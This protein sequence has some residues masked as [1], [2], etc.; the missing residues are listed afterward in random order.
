MKRL[1]TVLAVFLVLGFGSIAT[2]QQ[3]VDEQVDVRLVLVEALV[4]DNA[5]QPV[6]G[7]EKTDFQMTV[8]NHIVPIDTLD[9][10]CFDDGQ[11]PD[12]PGLDPR[13]VLVFDY[14]SLSQRDQKRVLEDAAKMLGDRKGANDQVM[15]VALANDLRVEQRF[16]RDLDELLDTLQRME[17]DRT[18]WGRRYD[19][20]PAEQY[21][22]NMA[23]LLDVLAAYDGSKAVMMYSALVAW[24]DEKEEWF[25]DL[26]SRAAVG[27]TVIYP[28]GLRGLQTE[29][30]KPGTRVLARMASD[31]G[32]NVG[33]RGNEASELYSEVERELGCRYSLGFYVDSAEARAPQDIVISVKRPSVTVRYPAQVRV[34][35]SEETRASRMRAAFADPEQFEHP[36]VRTLAYP[37]RPD[38]SGGW[39][40][41]VAVHAPVPIGRTA[42]TLTVSA[43]IFRDGSKVRSISKDVT[44]DPPE[45]GKGILPVTVYGDGIAKPG[46]H[47]VRVVLSKPGE[48]QVVSSVVE[49]DVPE[50]PKGE[51]VL[52]GP[53]LARVVDEGLAVRAD[54]QEPV[55]LRQ[56]IGEGKTFEPLAVHE[57]E[58]ADTLLLYWE[59]CRDGSTPPLAG[60]RI[61]RNIL[62]ESGTAVYKFDSTRLEFEG[63]PIGCHGG[64][65]R[66][67]PGTLA[68]G[69]Y[70]VELAVRRAGERIAEQTAPLLVD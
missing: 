25:R 55:L 51:L 43:E 6:R 41:F 56:T 8:K 35:S 32:G 63:D 14:D 22:E 21:V 37:I 46:R 4:T 13:L 27:R 3:P 33:K 2:A 54:D 58:P 36:L 30:P 19:Y 53:I 66:I 12:V 24:P 65:D 69:E 70:T 42:E 26:T 34:W 18:L 23:T 60:A 7:L 48:K 52:R 59:A 47:S 5:G 49:F 38:A 44:L 9:E 67:E 50:V 15:I 29:T 40:T 64:L 1:A 20:V 11:R 62:D 16:T 17:Y 10:I 28:T 68:P 45:S 57:I 31:T 61:D 39:F